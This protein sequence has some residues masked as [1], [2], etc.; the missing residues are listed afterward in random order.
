MTY[1]ICSL[2]YKITVERKKDEPFYRSFITL[3]ETF[4][5]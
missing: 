2:Y 3:L 1:N 4:N 5:L